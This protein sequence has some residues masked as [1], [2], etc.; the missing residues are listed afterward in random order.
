MKNIVREWGR[1]AYIVRIHFLRF[2]SDMIA[3]I[4]FSTL[5]LGPK[6]WTTPCFCRKF[7]I[8]LLLWAEVYIFKILM[9]K[10]PIPSTKECKSIWRE[11]IA[12]EI[13]ISSLGW[14]LSQSKCPYEKRKS[15]HK[16][17]TSGVHAHGEKAAV[18]KPRR[19]A[20]GKIKPE[21][22]F[23]WTSR[24][25]RKNCAFKSLHLW[26]SVMAAW[27]NFTANLGTIGWALFG[28]QSLTLKRL[29][30]GSSKGTV[31]SHILPKVHWFKQ[32]RNSQYS[33]LFGIV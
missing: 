3:W 33:S 4:L 32:V 11:V 2:F 20:W 26:Y 29:K 16:M 25:M 23:S 12:K 8:S 19:G 1:R 5:Y 24:I 28:V 9:L 18:W 31:D 13:Q 27:A 22:T 14:A 10:P 17:K 7:H 30:L 15:G 21:D 6:F